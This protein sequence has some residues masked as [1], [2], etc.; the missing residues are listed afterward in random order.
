M[1]KAASC[2]RCHSGANPSR[3]QRSLPYWA[4]H[5][6]TSGV[7][8]RNNPR[9]SQDGNGREATLRGIPHLPSVRRSS[10]WWSHEHYTPLPPRLACSGAP[11]FLH[12]R[13]PLHIWCLAAAY[14]YGVHKRV[15][16]GYHLQVVCVHASRQAHPFAAS[17]IPQPLCSTVLH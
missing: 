13:G 14:L 10:S 5:L 17:L 6:S 1:N 15:W 3:R 7:R 8:H 4:Y 12:H 11:C 2:F 16:Q 9:A